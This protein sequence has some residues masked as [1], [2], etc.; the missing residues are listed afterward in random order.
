MDVLLGLMLGILAMFSYGIENLL[1][2]KLSRRIGPFRTSFWYQ[3]IALAMFAVAAMFLL[4]NVQFSALTFCL[5]ILTAVVSVIGIISFNTGLRKG[6][7]SAISTVSSA[8]A[9]VTVILG[10][11]FLRESLSP[12]QVLCIAIIVVGTVLVSYGHGQGKE[13]NSKKLA[14]GMGWAFLTL[15][16]WGAYAFL[17]ALLAIS[18]GWF[19]AGFYIILSSIAVFLVYGFLSKQD[20]QFGKGNLLY[21]VPVAAF[22]VAASLSY[23]LGVTAS[24]TAVVATI[25]SASPFVTVLLAAIFMRERLTA[26]QKVGVMLILAGIV[27]LAL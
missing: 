20:F 18:I 14:A 27:L 12:Q 15:F 5:I 23:N 16:A 8:W 4:S 17:S 1:L 13:S 26:V 10:V 7:V 21:L 3:T 24:Y 11:I 9:V 25:T 22:D 19:N 2:A 6:N